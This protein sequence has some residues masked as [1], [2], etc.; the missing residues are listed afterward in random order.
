M[1]EDQMYI[2]KRSVDTVLIYRYKSTKTFI[3]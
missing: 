1:Y 3:R 2:N